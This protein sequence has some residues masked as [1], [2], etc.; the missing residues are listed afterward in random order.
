VNRSNFRESIRILHIV[1]D[2][3][4]GALIVAPI[5]H[6]QRELGYQVEFVS[7]TGEYLERL[8]SLG[9]SLVIIPI[10]RRLLAFSH[11]HFIFQ[12][13]KTIR[14]RKYHIVH[15][16][17]VIAS[18]LGRIAAMLART[19]IIIYHMRASWWASESYWARNSF[20]ILE[21]L[22]S[23]WT[24]HI[25]TINCIDRDEAIQKKIGNEGS[26]TCLHCGGGG[27]DV[28]RFNPDLFTEEQNAKMRAGLG[29]GN[30]DFVIGFVGRL[31]QEKGLLE[32]VDA[33][34]KVSRIRSKVKLLLVGGVLSSER[35]QST[36]A[37]LRQIIRDQNLEN[38]II[39]TDFQD[40]IPNFL[41][42]MNVLVLPSHRE[43][44]GM[45]LAEAASMGKPV[46]STNTRGGREAV[47][48]N[49]NGLLV[50]I[51]DIEALCLALIKLISDEG[52]RKRLGK[53]GRSLALEKFDE[54]VVFEKINFE[55]KRLI[56]NK[57]LPR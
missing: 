30:E 16:H 5:A 4:T 52:L 22:S 36:L 26:V 32:L 46:V 54:A 31:V 48:P 21:K 23:L 7:G 3:A 47:I 20:T 35:D 42:V 57:G 43:G 24:N 37:I 33:F 34:Q 2:P 14:S 13:W 11:L 50:P 9:F 8:Q 56:H 29:L 15:T 17:T 41:S 44:F 6:R 1:A 49:Q 38:Q 25:F 28:R 53:A 51:G 12:L 10:A 39:F 19:P 18:F 27:V 40:D 45:V 55:Y